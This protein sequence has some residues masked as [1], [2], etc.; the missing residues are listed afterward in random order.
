MHEAQL[1][2]H[3]RA[4]HE[5]P[6]RTARR[7]RR[8]PGTQGPQS[9]SISMGFVEVFGLALG[10]IAFGTV[11]ALFWRVLNKIF[12]AIEHH[13]GD[14]KHLEDEESSDEEGEGRRGFS[15]PFW[16]FLVYL[17]FLA[18]F[19]AVVYALRGGNSSPYNTH[20]ALEDWFTGNEFHYNVP[21]SGL[22][23]RDQ[24]YTWLRAVVVPGV[25]PLVRNDGSGR[26]LDNIDRLCLADGQSLRIGA[27]RLRKISA[28]GS[29]SVTDYLQDDANSW[30]A[31]N[32]HQ[33]FSNYLGPGL[34]GCS[35]SALPNED[36]TTFTS[37]TIRADVPRS[38]AGY[39]IPWRATDEPSYKSKITGSVYCGNGQL[40]DLSTNQTTALAELGMLRDDD[41][42]IADGTRALLA[43]FVLYNPGTE[44]F[45]LFRGAV[46]FHPAGAVVPTFD[47]LSVDLAGT[48][49]A[50]KNDGATMPQRICAYLEILLYMQVMCYI[51]LELKA[52]KQL[53]WHEYSKHYISL[54]TCVN[55][56][57]FMV[58]LFWRLINLSWVAFNYEDLLQTGAGVKAYP[59]E[60]ASNIVLYKTVDQF[61]AINAILSFFRLFKYLRAN[62]GLAQL[63]DTIYLATLELG[64]VMLI[65]VVCMVAYAAAFQLAFGAE[66]FDYNAMP[67]AMQ[68]MSRAIVGD[69]DFTVLM[70]PGRAVTNNT[71]GMCLCVTYVVVTQ[72]VVLSM[73]LA[74]LDHAY[75]DVR[76][77]LV[78]K[79]V[80][81]DTRHFN[82]D[83]SYVV[84]FPVTAFDWLIKQVVQKSSGT[85]VDFGKL[86]ERRRV[87]PAMLHVLKFEKM[88]TGTDHDATA[89]LAKV[90]AEKE[91]VLARARARRE[92][93]EHC[94]DTL[95]SAITQR[96]EAIRG[97]NAAARALGVAKVAA[98]EAP[99]E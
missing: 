65:L 49:R 55:L 72:F 62:P 24:V 58:A 39:S 74:I 63:S 79:I 54:L 87:D 25:L 56:A 98:Y 76:E 12:R 45:S 37:S 80:D 38:D 29:A 41:W 3:R 85:S 57:S 13:H 93:H 51:A 31:Q 22:N 81:D 2:A 19:V 88:A 91:A 95:A 40:W 96:D 64:P 50:W 33:V 90:K 9:T 42:L 66:L 60:L 99:G 11:M 84:G 32:L 5:Q 92:M 26:V 61:N 59:S 6:K 28:E 70:G 68:S 27:I 86:R 82:E 46:E 44:L 4:K 67:N 17:G 34:S 30:K 53:G 71:I 8:G 16:D 83:F 94:R 73:L 78:G 47:I 21:F 89:E 36:D 14:D 35:S 43:E 23:L 97:Q 18:T 69:F 10:L 52:M 1:P 20:V 48:Y 75:E 77:E 7:P 15:P